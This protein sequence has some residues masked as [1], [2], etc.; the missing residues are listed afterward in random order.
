MKTEPAPSN[1]PSVYRLLPDELR[2]LCRETGAPAFRARQIWRWLYVRNA[3]DWSAMKNLPADFRAALAEQVRLDAERI[4]KQEGSA[5]GAVKLLVALADGERIE[6]VLIP[7]PKRLTLCVSSQ[8]GCRYHCAFCASGQAGFRRH[9]HAGEMVAQFLLAWRN[10]QRKPTH[11]VF[12]GI[13]EPLDNY[14][15]VLKA[16]RI[17]NDPDGLRI[18]ARRITV[19]T[20]GLVPG[21]ERL[22]NESLQIELSVSLHAPDDA[23]RSSLMP[24]NRLHPLPDLMRAC[25]LYAEQ[26]GRIVTFE[27]TL[28]RNVNDAPEQAR[29]LA[30]LIAPLPCRVNLIPLSPVPE[31]DAVAAP[32]RAARLFIDTL[33]ASGINATLRA[34]RGTGVRAACGQLRAKTL[35]NNGATLLAP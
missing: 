16:I 12:M 1:R 2:A 18:A 20:C 27:Y 29:A 15:E 21:I 13:G 34:S 26:T 11:T 25:R 6:S 33:R 5:P 35:D 32:D 14:D 3:P 8:V 17:L 4:E 24:V 30:D 31:F 22:A 10:A 23:L 19:S 28:I 9:L 7:A